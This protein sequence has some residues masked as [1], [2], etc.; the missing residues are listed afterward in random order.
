[1]EREFAL[2][3]TESVTLEN[4]SK[5]RSMATE[6]FNGLTEEDMKDIE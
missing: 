1:M 2:E 5:I 4:T 3:A 6:Y